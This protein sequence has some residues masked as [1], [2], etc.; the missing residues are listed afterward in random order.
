[1]T[2][3]LAF[4][5]LKNSK[6]RNYLAYLSNINQPKILKNGLIVL[7]FMD[8]NPK[9]QKVDLNSIC[10]IKRYSLFKFKKRSMRPRSTLK[11]KKFL[12]FNV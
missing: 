8:Y 5:R 7:F 6:N 4:L 9:S 12:T 10:L 2:R 1:M 3:K 11:N